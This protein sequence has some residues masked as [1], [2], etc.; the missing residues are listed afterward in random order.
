MKP[1]VSICNFIDLK[2]KLFK[3]NFSNNKC[4]IW[5]GTKRE[6]GFGVLYFNGTA[7][8]THKLAY[9]LK[10]NIINKIKNKYFTVSHKCTNKLCFNPNHLFE[11]NKQNLF[12]SK[13]IKN[14]FGCWKWNG[15]IDGNGYAILHKKNKR[16][17]A[18]RYSYEYYFGKFPKY[19]IHNNKLC[20]CHKCDN[21]ICTNPKHLFLGT[22]KENMED[23]AKKGR[24]KTF[25]GENHKRAILKTS[26]VFRIRKLLQT[27]SMSI[28]DIAVKFKVSRSLIG[29]IKGGRAWKWLK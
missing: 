6:T 17:L 21:P 28:S 9:C 19:D 1:I 3:N 27:N 15:S 4:W 14:K 5:N 23:M 13:V 11:R 26:D 7:Y 12:L 10:N 18:H 22:H 24:V 29:N 8:T 20:I 25:R 16:I 2:N